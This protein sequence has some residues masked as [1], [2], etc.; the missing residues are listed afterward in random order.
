MCL[1]GSLATF[2]GNDDVC[3]TLLLL[4][5]MTSASVYSIVYFLAVFEGP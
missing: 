1:S 4:R 3:L 5:G 2:S